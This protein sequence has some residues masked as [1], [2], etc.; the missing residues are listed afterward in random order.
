MNTSYWKRQVWRFPSLSRPTPIF[1]NKINISFNKIITMNK[2]VD[3]I[4]IYIIK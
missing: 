2:S 3:S 1:E 4:Q